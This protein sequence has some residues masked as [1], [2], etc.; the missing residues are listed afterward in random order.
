M[1][2]PLPTVQPATLVTGHGSGGT[3]DLQRRHRV[4][5][6]PAW[7][8]R[9]LPPIGVQRTSVSF[10]P[11]FLSRCHFRARRRAQTFSS[12]RADQPATAS[13]QTSHGDGMM[14]ASPNQTP[15][16]LVQTP[17]TSSSPSLRMTDPPTISF[18]LP[19]QETGH[20]SEPQ[21]T[22]LISQRQQRRERSR[23][24]SQPP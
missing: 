21:I 11:T 7:A 22:T 24:C 1:Y 19:N 16:R 13:H 18:H 17:R 2:W 6:R 20:Q 9:I 23:R 3:L 4:I 10:F 5:R 12:S 8:R 14:D 15:G